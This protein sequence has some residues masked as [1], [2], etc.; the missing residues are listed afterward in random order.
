[1]F[2]L[3]VWSMLVS[4]CLPLERDP[5]VPRPYTPGHMYL[6]LHRFP[7]RMGPC[8]CIISWTFCQFSSIALCPLLA[9][10]V[11]RADLGPL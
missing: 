7:L 11:L 3:L 9:T 1:M 6:C 10:I 4:R 8:V 5:A 2:E